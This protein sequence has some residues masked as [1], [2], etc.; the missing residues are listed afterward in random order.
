MTLEFMA[1]SVNVILRGNN[2]VGK[3]MLAKNVAYQALAQG[4]T[5]RFTT[6]GE[7]LSL[8]HI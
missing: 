2:G 8:I 1:Q 6:A 7:M 3:S 4:F 5:V